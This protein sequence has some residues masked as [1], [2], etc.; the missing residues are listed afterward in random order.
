[1]R[2]NKTDGNNSPAASSQTRRDFLA[3]TIRLAAGAAIGLL[4]FQLIKKVVAPSGRTQ[5]SCSNNYYCRACGKL[6]A[7]VFPQ[8]LSLKQNN[9]RG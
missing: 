2:K 5:A 1:M 8:A 3:K 6:D 4:G 9:G 7:C